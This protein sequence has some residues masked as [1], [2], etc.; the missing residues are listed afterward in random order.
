[1]NTR[2]RE[3]E[4]MPDLLKALAVFLVVWGH[5]IQYFTPEGYDLLSDRVFRD[6]Y[7]FHMPLFALVSG[8]LFGGS[9]KR[10]PPGELAIKRLRQ[11]LIPSALFVLLMSV[12]QVLVWQAG[13]PDGALIPAQFTAALSNWAVNFPWF[14][15]GTLILSLLA[16]LVSGPLKGHPA[17]WCAM[18]LLPLITP[19]DAHLCEIAFILPYF[20]FGVLWQHRGQGLR[21][22]PLLGSLS[23]AAWHVMIGRYGPAAWVYVTGT[24]LVFGPVTALPVPQ[25][26]LWVT[27]RYATGFAACFSVIWLVSLFEDFIRR[28]PRLRRAAAILSQ[29]SG[30]VYMLSCYIMSWLID[31]T[32]PFASLFPRLIPDHPTVYYVAVLIP[33]SLLTIG[34]L[35]AL[36]R[37]LSCVPP[38]SRA[39]L[40]CCWKKVKSGECR[41]VSGE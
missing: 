17:A 3:R 1:M 38:L 31:F 5:N 8:Y 14:Y 4:L 9:L 28:H 33:I 25:Q 11:L 7:C 23:M 26:L 2:V 35:L 41:V 39:L 22:S 40:G 21:V 16:I 36:Y 32:R 29:A 6:I 34:L 30:A 24:S 37:L 10:T 12:I 18:L 20:V 15:V 19:Y 27:F 13:Q